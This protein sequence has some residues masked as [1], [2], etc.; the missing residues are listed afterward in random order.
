MVNIF[1]SSKSIAKKAGT[2]YPD[3][4]AYIITFCVSHRR[5]KM[6]CGHARL[7]VCLSV[8]VCPRLYAH[9]IARIRM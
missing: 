4:L 9:T 8:C 6:Y 3:T 1:Y 7:C 2:L 5:R